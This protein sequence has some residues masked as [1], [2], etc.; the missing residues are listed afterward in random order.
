MPCYT[1]VSI[2]VNDEAVAKNVMAKLENE[3]GWRATISKN[4]NGTYTVTPQQAYPGFEKKFN[5]EYAAS[6]ATQKAKAAGYIVTRKDQ[7]N[8]IELILRQY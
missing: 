7:D 3:H 1:R 6:L 8:K 4:S 5:N 2:N